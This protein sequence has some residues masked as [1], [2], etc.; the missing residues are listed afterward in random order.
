MSE[1]DDELEE[2]KKKVLRV[3]ILLCVSLV[4][5]VLIVIPLYLHSSA[6]ESLK[7]TWLESH[8]NWQIKTAI[9]YIFVLLIVVVAMILG[10]RADNTSLKDIALLVSA[11]LGVGL[12][13]IWVLYRVFVG[14]MKYGEDAEIGKNSS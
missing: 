10:Y 11:F 2:K 4:L 1:I 9:I 7:T 14:L 5:P 6:K 8:G 12:I 3:Y 13:N